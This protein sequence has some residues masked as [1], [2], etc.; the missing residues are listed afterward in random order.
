MLVYEF[1]DPEEQINSQDF[2]LVESFLKNTGRTEIGW[3]YIIDITWI[4]S[5][6][7]HWPRH[8][9]ILD[10]GGGG[11]PLQ[12]FLAEM[13]YNITNIDML[14]QEPPTA[15]SKRYSMGLQALQSYTPTSYR[16]HIST[17][18]KK[19]LFNRSKILLKKTSVYKRL[20]ARRYNGRHNRWRYSLDML[21]A[22]TGN[23]KWIKGNLCAMPEIQ[24]DAFD[25]VVSLSALEHIPS[26][27]LESALNEIRRVLKPDAHFAITTSGTEQPTTWFHEPSQGYCFSVDDFKKFFAA[28]N[29]KSEEP[30]KI[31]EKYR[32]CVYLKDNLAEFYKKSGKFGMPWGKWDPKYIPVGIYSEEIFQE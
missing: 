1:I 6:I 7:K 18:V 30:K 29:R 5:K 8:L 15:Y 26:E 13:G 23:V 17:S 3:H 22:P 10:A 14:H 2:K 16:K 4:Y 12:F 24:P 19:S 27:M 21:D 11:G 32:Q 20:S 25:A 9:H 28:D 31:L